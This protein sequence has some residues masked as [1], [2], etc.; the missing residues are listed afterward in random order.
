M[1]FDSKTY[2]AWVQECNRYHPS[3]FLPLWVGDTRVGSVYRGNLAYFTEFPEVFVL[4]D[5]V[6]V[7]LHPRLETPHERSEALEIATRAWHDQGLLPPWRNEPY[8]VA[9]HFDAPP[10]LEVER[11]A[12]S[13][14]GVQRY[15]VH[16]N[17]LTRRNGEWMMWVGRRSPHSATYPDLYDQMVAG[18]VAA[19]MTPW[20]TL[21]KECAEEADIPETLASQAKPVG[22]VSYAME[23]RQ[24]MVRDVL[25]LYDLELPADFVPHNADGEAAGFYLWPLAEV[26]RIVSETR[27]FKLNTN[28]VVIDFLIR[29]GWLTPE[30]PYF[31]EICLGLRGRFY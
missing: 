20:Q 25:F 12:A 26:A 18:G 27:D 29:H 23:H 19:G 1:T 21:L 28:L 3:D 15:G 2:L 7:R 9:P 6:A 30:Q 8:R 17:G 31:T 10:L 4:E 24:R 22:L 5:D 14:L 13:F 11:A 16:L